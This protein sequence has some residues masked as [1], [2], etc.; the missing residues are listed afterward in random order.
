M[1]RREFIGAAGLTIMGVVG[2]TEAA[3]AA[4]A[5]QPRRETKI[6]GVTI[7]GHKPNGEVHIQT[8]A[9]P[10][11]LLLGDGAQDQRIW[12][13]VAALWAAF[14]AGVRNPNAVLHYVHRTSQDENAIFEGVERI[15]LR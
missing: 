2:T 9:G 5:A 15:H 11:W 4:R 1:E 13:C 6:T 8:E 7:V 10:G 14:H 12:A 3:E